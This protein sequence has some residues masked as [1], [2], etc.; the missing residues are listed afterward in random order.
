MALK[1]NLPQFF[2][3]FEPQCQVQAEAFFKCFEENAAMKHRNDSESCK[4]A[5]GICVESLDAYE[6]C[7]I[8]ALAQRDKKPWW[9]VW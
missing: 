3:T 1:R 4:L 6:Q 7:N 5:V 9:K 8:K 2:P